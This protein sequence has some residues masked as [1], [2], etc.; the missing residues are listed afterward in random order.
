VILVLCQDFAHHHYLLLVWQPIVSSL[1]YHCDTPKA[2]Q[3]S[4]IGPL[5][6][7]LLLRNCKNGV[8][9]HVIRLSF[10]ALMQENAQN[11]MRLLNL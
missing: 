9:N 10:I 5:L 4:D 2:S 8:F 6:S 1:A 7:A 3:I 11:M